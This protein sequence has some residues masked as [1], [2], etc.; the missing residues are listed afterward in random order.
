MSETEDLLLL[1]YDAQMPTKIKISNDRYLRFTGEGILSLKANFYIGLYD[2]VKCFD[3][4]QRLP[5]R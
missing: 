5:P 1:K 2:Q 4:V 3:I